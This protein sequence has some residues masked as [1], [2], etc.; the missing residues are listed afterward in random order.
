MF[1]Y[2]KKLKEQQESWAD[3]QYR[4]L[5]EEMFVARRHLEQSVDNVIIKSGV[6]NLYPD[7]PDKETAEKALSEAKYLLLCAISYFDGRRRDLREFYDKHKDELVVYADRDAYRWKDSHT[8]IEQE[9]ENFLKKGLTF[10]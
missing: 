4:P 7:G 10:S 8:C 3:S 9:Y 1:G 2:F 6:V 5:W